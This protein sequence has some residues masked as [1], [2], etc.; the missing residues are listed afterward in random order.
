MSDE[1]PSDPLAGLRKRLDRARAR[2]TGGGG[3][4]EPGG[5]LGFGMRVGI[6]L[7]AAL[8]VGVAIGLGI[9]YALGTRPWGLIAFFFVGSAAGIANV[10]RATQRMG[11]GGGL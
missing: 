2:E 5:A 10:F 1:Q 7:I 6:E 8:I 9:D 3:A 11:R 4:A